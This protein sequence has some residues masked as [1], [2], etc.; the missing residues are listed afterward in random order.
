MKTNR[1]I[2]EGRGKERWEG[3]AGRRGG[4]GNC[5]GDVKKISKQMNE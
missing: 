3:G 1:G 2:D 5:G 4:R